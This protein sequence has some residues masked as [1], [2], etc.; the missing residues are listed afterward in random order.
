M[1]VKFLLGTSWGIKNLL[2][3]LWS[4]TLLQLGNNSFQKSNKY[5]IS[6]FLFNTCS[7]KGF[8]PSICLQIFIIFQTLF[9]LYKLTVH[10]DPGKIIFVFKIGSYVD[11]VWYFEKSNHDCLEECWNLFKTITLKNM[12]VLRQHFFKGRDCSIKGAA[13]HLPKIYEFYRKIGAILAF[14]HVY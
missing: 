14:Q 12:V 2:N 7:Y 11:I 8:P 6:I 4:W 13:K 10:V 3:W 5:I 1:F 9:C